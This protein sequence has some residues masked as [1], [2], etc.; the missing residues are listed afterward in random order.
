MRYVLPLVVMA[1]PA[2]AHEG[3]HL[4]PHS[5]E[6]WVTGL[7]VLALAGVVAIRLRK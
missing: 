6:G 2:T 4:H 7:A 1:G 3:A 5:V